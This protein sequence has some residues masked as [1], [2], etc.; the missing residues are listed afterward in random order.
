MGERP[1]KIDGR[2]PCHHTSNDQRAFAVCLR[3][4]TKKIPK[5]VHQVTGNNWTGRG[6]RPDWL[7]EPFK[8]GTLA[9]TFWSVDFCEKGTMPNCV[10]ATST[11]V[12]GY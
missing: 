7:S 5:Y 11:P 8:A 3:A 2:H 9:K 12:V 6:S 4:K 10:R 1:S